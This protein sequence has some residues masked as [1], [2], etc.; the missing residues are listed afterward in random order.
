MITP[1]ENDPFAL[2]WMAFKNL[3]PNKECKIW[4]DKKEPC[5]NG[6]TVVLG[7]TFF[8]DD[9]TTT[10]FIDY[11]LQVK[12]AVEI[13]A[14]ELAHVAAGEDAAHG[15]T[16]EKAFDAIFAEYNRLGYKMFDRHDTVEVID[17]KNSVIEVANEE[18]N[19][20]RD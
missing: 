7:E 10:V 3:Y 17:G 14:H 6:G 12:N 8:E 18:E 20:H 11:D 4:Y 2:V 16:W 9:G 13:F 5:E 15:E 19:E 1:F